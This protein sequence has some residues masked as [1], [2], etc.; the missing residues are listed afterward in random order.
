MRTAIYVGFYLVA[1]AINPELKL[2]VILV[3]LP[4]L[5]FLLDLAEF[6]KR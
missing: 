1:M 3:V 6:G 2:S 4:C 5:L